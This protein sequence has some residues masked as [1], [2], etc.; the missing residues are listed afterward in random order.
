MTHQ[1]KIKHQRTD[2]R[3]RTMPHVLVSL[4]FFVIAISSVHAQ[5]IS[6]DRGVRV[7]G[8]WCFPLVTD[9]TQYLFLPDRA[10]LAI[11]EKK[12]PQFSFIRYVTLSDS[13]SSTPERTISQAG[14][15]GVLHF[16]VTYDTDEKKVR[17]AGASLRELLNN[18]EVRLRGPIVFKEGRFALVSSILDPASGK[19]ER[20]LMSM[21][22]AP[23][24]QGSKIALSF[25][26][27]PQYSTLLLES[28]K[29]PTPDV[30][31]VFDLV[32]SGLTDAYSAK[33]TVDWTE[34]YKYEKI[35]GGANVY[36]VSAELEKIYE[37]L[38]KNNAIKLEVAGEDA[39]MDNLLNNAYG[40]LTDMLF[41]RVEPEQ[42]PATDQGGLGGMLSGLFSNNGNGAF[43]SGKTFGFGAHFGYKR[44]DTKTSGHSVLNF[45]SRNNADR[46]HYITFNI[47]DFYQKYGKDGDYIKTVSLSDPDFEKRDIYVGV[48]GA[49]VPEFD[50]MINSI[51]VTLRKAHQ[52][53]ST[54][55]REVNIVKSTIAEAKN[56]SMSYGSV[57]DADRL[58]WLNYD[59]KAQ[60]NFKGGKTY[61]AEWK[62]QNASMINLFAPYE[63]RVIRME[64]DAETLRSR[65]VR[66]TTVKIEYPFFGEKK[67]MEVTVKPEDDLSKKEF[68]ITLPAGQY[69][70]KYTVRWRMKDGT[71]QVMTG[72]NDTE[73]LFIDVFP[74][75]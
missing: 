2:H 49:L 7:E 27:D 65:N 31:I 10:M 40:K 54:T 46:H 51:T 69:A 9:T 68:D 22:A 17:D 36:F 18:D 42:I 63:R 67:I 57:G 71:E 3:A 30:S 61:Q 14:G 70:Y 47:G 25:E 41:R 39:R 50:K 55:L 56:I 72:D 24:L 35:S 26:M 29:M 32:F 62:Q 53:G 4:I 73:I 16:L 45:N 44:K 52:N 60:Y 66:A 21:G 8:L 33:L 58:A 37:E 1:N 20:T 75:K 15:G 23:V 38:Q 34:V 64:A 59:F 28:L 19:T 5:Q 74:E 11:D 13:A 6:I 43:S 48:D 12:R